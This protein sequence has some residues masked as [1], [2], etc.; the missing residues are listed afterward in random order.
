MILHFK[1]DTIHLIQTKI[2]YSQTLLVHAYV[3]KLPIQ[4][5]LETDTYK[6]FLFTYVV[7]NF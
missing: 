7:G 5:F 6:Y 4:N 3:F 1:N 2:C